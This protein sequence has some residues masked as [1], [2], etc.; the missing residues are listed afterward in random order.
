MMRKL[1]ITVAVAA[2]AAATAAFAAPPPGSAGKN[3]NAAC[4][5]LQAQLGDSFS[6]AYA[7]F[8]ACVSAL[9]PIEQQNLNAAQAAC[10]AEQADVS[11]AATHNG[12][13]FVQFYGSGHNAAKNAFGRCVAMKA[14]ASSSVEVSN[15]PNP[16]RACAAL[17]AKLGTAA[18][19][20][21]YGTNANH[22]NAF[23]KCVSQ[24][25]NAQTTNETSAA[26][27][28][29]TEQSD[30]NFAASHG[31]KTFAQLYGTNAKD[32]NAF[33]MCVSSKAKASRNAQLQATVSAAKTCKAVLGADAS[34]FYT[35]Y[36]TFGDCVSQKTK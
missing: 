12:K 28:C 27:V 8:G 30:A 16:A 33:G 14:S 18:F 31:G 35:K 36:G 20:L 2:L 25:A 3:A 29:L 23:G 10:T 15:T 22:R 26:A 1:I 6:T 4:Q 19:R 24:Q 34:A 21:L 32:T 13:T 17:Q 9:T 7:S 11:F 5:A